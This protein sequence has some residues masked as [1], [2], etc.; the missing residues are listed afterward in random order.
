VG[1]NISEK[2]TVYIFSPEDEDSKFVRNVGIYLQ[3]HTALQPRRPTSRSYL[4]SSFSKSRTPKENVSFMTKID[5]TSY[6]CQCHWPSS[7]LNIQVTTVSWIEH[8]CDR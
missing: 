5:P 7:E 2:Y 3:V 8:Y 1:T 4:T 6:I